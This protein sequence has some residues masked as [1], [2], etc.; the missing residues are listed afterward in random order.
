[1]KKKIYL[2]LSLDIIHHGH[3][4]II[5]HAKKLGDL[6]IGLL[7][8]KAVSSHKRMPLLNYSQRKEIL[9]NID[10][11]K[12][13]VPQT[14]WEHSKNILKY[15]PDIVVAG[16]DWKLSEA[17]RILRKNT[18][19]A[20][21]KIGAKLME[22]PYTKDI[23]SDS[24]Q[25][26]IFK[27]GLALSERSNYF[28]RLIDAK[29]IVRILETHSP[30]SA[31]IAQ[32]ITYTDKNNRN[33]EFDGFWSSSLT[34][35]TLRG[36][37]DIE[38]LDL[39]DRLQNIND[40]FDVTTKP[41]VI[42]IDTGGKTEHFEINIRTIERTGVSAV[43]MEDK[44]GLKKNSLFGTKVK[45]EQESIKE[46][47]NKIKKGKNNVKNLMII[48][49]VESLILN[50]PLKDALN[51]AENY[52][53]AGA[54]GIMIHSRSNSPKEVFDFA[55]K[56]KKKFSNIPLVAVPSS[57]NKTKERELINNGFDVVIYANHMLRASYPAMKNVALEILKNQRSYESDKSL[58]SIKK[59]LDLIPGTK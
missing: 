1:M 38:I 31:M 6:T 13:I 3:I 14:E 11:V 26:R 17:G 51:R 8:D 56:F 54:D 41:L 45:Q 32:N 7:T 18:I 34:D 46:F 53:G 22:F 35:S 12:R 48:A 20:I 15:K 55:E 40:I 10:G 24:L 2:S 42:D 23:S 9:E 52:V 4:K 39:R 36:K 30:L 58:L 59:I 19:Q 43:I 37:P 21:K 49:R 5:K 57:Y 27:Q 50:K 47:S 25:N 16:N 44:K 29:D 28:R 33:F